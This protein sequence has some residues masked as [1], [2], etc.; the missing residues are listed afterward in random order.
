MVV[1][2]IPTFGMVGMGLNKDLNGMKKVI[3]LQTIKL[4]HQLSCLMMVRQLQ[5]VTLTMNL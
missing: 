3:I 4:G 1:L 2:L 5:Q